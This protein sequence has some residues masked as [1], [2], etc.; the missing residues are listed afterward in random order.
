MMRIFR[1]WQ[2]DLVLSGMRIDDDDG[3]DAKR[4]EVDSVAGNRTKRS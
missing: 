4:G 3:V 2:Q 1:I